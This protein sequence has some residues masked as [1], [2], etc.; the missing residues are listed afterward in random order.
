M[1]GVIELLHLPCNPLLH[2]NLIRFA[3]DIQ[4]IPLS[5]SGSENAQRAL[6]ERSQNTQKNAQRTLRELQEN[7]QRTLR[8]HS[9]NAQR[10]L[11]CLI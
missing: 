5:V 2:Q 3:P 1:P 10:T 8:E 11:N 6:R 9:E 7:T 4:T